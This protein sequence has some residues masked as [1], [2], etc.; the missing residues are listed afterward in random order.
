MNTPMRMPVPL[1]LVLVFVLAT[2]ACS[3]ERR[4]TEEPP[5]SCVELVRLLSSCFHSAKVG[6][7]AKR[8]LP[9]IKKG[10]VEA[11]EKLDAECTRNLKGL[12]EDCR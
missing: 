5:S 11:L 6:E 7:D 12:K 2:Q 8:G 1:P 3:T 9:T 4:T 10:D